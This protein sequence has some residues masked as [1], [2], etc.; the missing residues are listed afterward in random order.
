[1]K[2]DLTLSERKELRLFFEEINSI[3]HDRKSN[4]DHATV[5]I[6]NIK[7]LAKLLVKMKNSYNKQEK[8]ALMAKLPEY[9][10]KIEVEVLP[11]PPFRD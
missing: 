4:E 3:A 10:K 7:E 8:E 11:L 1:M 5:K 2:D 9:I 6:N